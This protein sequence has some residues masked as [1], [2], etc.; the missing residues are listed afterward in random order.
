MSP[1]WEQP[2]CNSCRLLQV[3]FPPDIQCPVLRPWVLDRPGKLH[4]H[5]VIKATNSDGMAAWMNEGGK[6]AQN[7]ENIA[8]TT[9]TLLF[10]SMW[11][12]LTW[13]FRQF[14]FFLDFM[15]LL[16]FTA[17]RATR[18][19]KSQTWPAPKQRLQ[20][21]QL[22][23]CS[24]SYTTTTATTTTIRSNSNSNSNHNSNNN[25]NSNSITY[26]RRG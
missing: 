9:Q 20:Y 18:T 6:M 10:V 5:Q 8:S 12:C 4:L 19:R 3:N 23:V 15:V 1:F 17:T 16:V 24:S 26:V 22:L 14:S 2:N 7:A 25:N 21:Q 13:Y 11:F